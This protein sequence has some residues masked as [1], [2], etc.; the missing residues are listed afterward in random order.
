[1]LRSF[2][3]AMHA[4]ARQHGPGSSESGTVPE[5]W[6]RAGNR[7][8]AGA[9]LGAYLDAASGATFLP[10]SPLFIKEGNASA[11]AFLL[12]VRGTRSWGRRGPA[13]LGTTLPKSSSRGSV[14]IVSGEASLR[15]IPCSLA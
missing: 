14:N 10:E 15:N 12:S 6:L 9:F 2:S 1:M 4:A 3:Y 5:P 13:K 8:L 7:A 11:K